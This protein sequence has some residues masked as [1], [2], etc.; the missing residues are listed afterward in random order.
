MDKR[1]LTF[2]ALIL[3][4]FGAFVFMSNQKKDSQ[5][6]DV[7]PSNHVSGKLDS[8]VTFLEYGD[9][10]CPACASFEPAV[11]Q[12]RA[13]YGDRAK[14]QFRNL[15]ITQ[16]HP[17]AM[18]AARA[19]E[20]AAKQGKFWEM[21]NLL[22]AQSNWTAWTNDTDPTERL[23]G[24]ARQLMLNESQFKTDFKSPAVNDTIAADRAEFEKYKVQVST[25]TF[26]INGK[27]VSNDK[28]TGSDG[29]PSAEA[30][31]KLIDEALKKQQ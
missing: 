29:Q 11:A 4:G 17:N 12:A 22:Y 2:L 9:Y 8:K 21:H 20:A 27:Q 5:L 16:I 10:Q 31:G 13:L 1:F 15:P 28:M 18:A 14:F 7:K 25:P 6:A 30:I 23:N 26:F 19:A 24:Y 3:V